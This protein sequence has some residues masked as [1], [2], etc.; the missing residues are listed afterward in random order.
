MAKQ[1]LK[2]APRDWVAHPQDVRLLVISPT[3]IQILGALTGTPG[4]WGAFILVPPADSVQISTLSDDDLTVKFET[5]GYIE[6]EHRGN[7]WR[8]SQPRDATEP[9][10]LRSDADS[11]NTIGEVVTSI[12]AHRTSATR[13]VFFT[14][15]DTAYSASTPVPTPE[16]PA[17]TPEAPAL[18]ER[19]PG[20]GRRKKEMYFGEFRR[21]VQLVDLGNPV[22]LLATSESD[23]TSRVPK[24]KTNGVVYDQYAELAFGLAT[25][26]IAAGKMRLGGRLMRGP[27]SIAEG[28]T[29]YRL[30]GSFV[31]N[32]QLELIIGYGP[33]APTAAAAGQALV[34]AVALEA[35]PGG[36]LQIDRLIALKREY[37]TDG[38]TIYD[39]L[40]VGIAVVNP[41]VKAIAAYLRGQLSI[42]RLVGAP[43]LLVDRNIG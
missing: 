3:G 27:G 36:D 37:L 41:T 21:D 42:Q 10:Q 16:A 1:V 26:A 39:P 4:N 20:G 15:S 43:P 9:Y 29:V 38:T 17:P 19:P 34:G 30:M 23:H 2:S 40:F 22:A 32:A 7:V 13:S 6:V 18:T 5:Q 14:I 12:R 31:S 35:A 11:P 33:V 24:T 8:G 28:R 25:V